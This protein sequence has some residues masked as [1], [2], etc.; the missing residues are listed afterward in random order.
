[1]NPIHM[2]LGTIVEDGRCTVPEAIALRLSEYRLQKHD[3]VFARR[4]ELGRCALVKERETGWLCGT[5]SILVR[6]AYDTVEPDNL[7]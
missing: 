4:G 3:I 6:P 1:M 5:G 7:Y 2:R